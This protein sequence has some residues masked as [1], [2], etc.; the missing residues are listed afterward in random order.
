MAEDKDKGEEAR[1]IAPPTTLKD[2]V[3]DAPLSTDD[4]KAI[5]RAQAVIVKLAEKYV[6]TETY[7]SFLV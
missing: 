2:K 5:E 4:L 1:I 6:G 7:I 3:G